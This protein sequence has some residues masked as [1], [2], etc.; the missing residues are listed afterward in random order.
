VEVM[1]D[2]FGI[3]Q[4]TRTYLGSWSQKTPTVADGRG[5]QITYAMDRCEVADLIAANL[6]DQ[7]T[8]FDAANELS[9]NVWVTNATGDI[10]VRRDSPTTFKLGMSDSTSFTF[11]DQSIDIVFRMKTAIPALSLSM[12]WDASTKPKKMSIYRDGCTLVETVLG[13]NDDVKEFRFSQAVDA[14]KD[15]YVS[16]ERDVPRSGRL[17]TM[18]FQPTAPA[19]SPPVSSSSGSTGSSSTGGPAPILPATNNTGAILGGILA[20]VIVLAA[21]GF[22]LMWR[23]KQKEKH[24]AGDYAH[25]PMLDA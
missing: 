5:L 18:G 9:W 12:T 23:N 2:I 13:F 3:V 16:L 20:V 6:P 7:T 15:L 10:A 21:V 22:G 11:S 8:K 25:M 24:S 14:G 19:P 4:G 17:T 1:T